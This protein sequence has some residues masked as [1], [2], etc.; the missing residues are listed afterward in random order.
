MKGGKFCPKCGSKNLVPYVGFEFGMKY[1]CRDCGY[2]G[3]LVVEKDLGKK[4]EK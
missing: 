3:V 4:K 2:M 1:E